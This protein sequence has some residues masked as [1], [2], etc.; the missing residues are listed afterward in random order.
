MIGSITYI[1]ICVLLMVIAMV[2][3]FKSKRYAVAVAYAALCIAGLIAPSEIQMTPLLFW[4]VALVIVLVIDMLLPA[5]I[6]KSRQGLGYIGGGA[7]V[8]MF[9]GL[10]LHSVVLCIV[11][12]ALLGTIAYAK[13]PEGKPLEFP[14]SKFLSYLC[15]KGFPVVI[16]ICIIGVSISWLLPDFLPENP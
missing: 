12:G 2:M 16:A 6:A 5:D 8:G 3:T 15:A 1:S 4:G 14:S 13:T 7:I 11:V 10:L 9:V